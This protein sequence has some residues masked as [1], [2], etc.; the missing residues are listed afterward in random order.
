[1]AVTKQDVMEYVGLEAEYADAVQERRIERALSAA[2]AWLKGAVGSDVNMED[3][4]AEEL[5]LMAAGELFETRTLTDD[6][7]SKYAGA[8]VLA[9]VNRMAG[10]TIMQLKYCVSEQSEEGTSV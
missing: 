6:R 2:E 1:M 10:D 4:R 5:V 7:L 8:K 9:S 3:P